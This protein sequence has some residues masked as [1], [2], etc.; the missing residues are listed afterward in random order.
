LGF[1]DGAIVS[2]CGANFDGFAAFDGGANFGGAANVSGAVL[3]E[4]PPTVPR[5]LGRD[6]DL[7]RGD[8][9]RFFDFGD[10]GR[11]FALEWIKESSRSPVRSSLVSITVSS[12]ALFAAKND[13]ATLFFVEW[14]SPKKA[15]LAR[16]FLAIF[17]L[18]T[19]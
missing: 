1:F 4:L 11:F 17:S 16:K 19:L 12:V 6:L 14:Q 18:T 8:G 15:C 10:S 3:D 9:G 2:T 13:S 5:S 7:I